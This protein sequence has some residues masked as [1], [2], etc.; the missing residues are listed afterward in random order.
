MEKSQDVLKDNLN[1]AGLKPTWNRGHSPSPVHHAGA[2]EKVEP[3][4][5]RGFVLSPVV[6]VDDLGTTLNEY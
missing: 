2:A 1:L 6:I 4:P 3:A 5:R